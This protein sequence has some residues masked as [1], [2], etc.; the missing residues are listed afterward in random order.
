M[1]WLLISKV[2]CSLWCQHLL[3]R[4][5]RRRDLI[6][7]GWVLWLRR[8]FDKRRHKDG[9]GWDLLFDELSVLQHVHEPANLE[10]VVFPAVSPY[11]HRGTIWEF[12]VACIEAWKIVI[13]SYYWTWTKRIKCGAWGISISTARNLA[14]VNDLPVDLVAQL[15]QEWETDCVWKNPL[16]FVGYLPGQ[17]VRCKSHWK[18]FEQS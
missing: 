12:F 13:H 3:Q 6:S 10:A 7:P 8:H 9:G 1:F 11:R 14:K 17:L 5:A 15:T 2:T 18:T 4:A 16:D